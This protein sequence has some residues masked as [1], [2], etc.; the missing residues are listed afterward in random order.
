MPD[1]TQAVTDLEKAR[2]GLASQLL[3]TPGNGDLI[4]AKDQIEAE[5]NQIVTQGLSDSPYVP[6]TDAFKAVTAQAKDF[7]T[8]LTNIKNA[9]GAASALAGLID[10]VIG[11]IK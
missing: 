5:I 7:F 10:K 11:Y 6:Q 3:A 1:F 9:A 8:K 4:D 2:D